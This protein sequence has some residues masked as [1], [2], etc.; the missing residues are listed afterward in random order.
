MHLGQKYARIFVLG[1][2]LFLVAHSFPRAALSENCSLLG[3]DNVRGQ[4]SEH[5]FAPNGD[6]CLYI[7]AP[8]GG[9][10]LSNLWNLIRTGECSW[11]GGSLASLLDF[12]LC[13]SFN[14]NKRLLLAKHFNELMRKI[15]EV[16]ETLVYVQEQFCY[17]CWRPTYK[18]LTWIVK[19]VFTFTLENQFTFYLTAVC[20]RASS[21]LNQV[22]GYLGKSGESVLVLVP[23]LPPHPQLF[24][25]Y[26]FLAWPAN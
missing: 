23:Y 11:L 26:C 15:L 18:P 6:Y 25:S 9:Y 2:Y 24:F 13:A 16:S 17:T 7:F 12:L 14:N 1:H 21:S 19:C 4:I 10:C 20:W 8:N 3:T 5:I 22:V